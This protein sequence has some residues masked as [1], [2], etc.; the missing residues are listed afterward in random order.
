MKE[1][2]ITIIDNYRD[3]TLGDYQD[4]CKIHNDETI[5]DLDKDIKVVSILTGK[6]EDTILDLPIVDYKKL[7]A[8]LDF[9]AKGIPDNGRVADSYI[10][11]GYELI[12]VKDI[13]KVNTAQY[14]DFQTFHKVGMEEHFVEILSC[15]LVPKG[16]KYNQ[17]YDILDV[18]SA[19]REEMNVYDGVSLYGFFMMSCKESI[20]D[21]L[22]FSLQ[23]AQKL[24][25]QDKRETMVA[26][27]RRQMILLETDG[28]GLPM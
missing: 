11:G 19:I 21:M 27:I 25:D 9:L 26:E 6:D 4:I 14:I 8:R 18:Q 15:L 1:E 12:P 24:T 3:L 17:D 28:V 7:T 22:T 10:V 5:D 13:R 2:D 23:E 20:K 16:K